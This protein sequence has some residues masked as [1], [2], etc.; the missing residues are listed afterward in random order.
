MSMLIAPDSPY[1]KELWK[2]EHRADE[3]HPQDSSLRGMRPATPQAYPAMMYKAT[4][5]NPWT[6]E[7]EVAADEVVQRNM[8]SRGFVAGG[9][10][11]AAEAFDGLV[12]S[13]ALA[14]AHRNYEDRNMSE[15]ARAHSEAVEQSSSRHLGEIP[16]EPIPAH[17]KRGRPAKAV[18]DAA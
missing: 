2:W 4:G 14:A 1:G 3:T 11:K 18:A 6:F 15:G 13:A 10:G 5:K 12:Q 17:R 8:E 7:R 16:A 9:P